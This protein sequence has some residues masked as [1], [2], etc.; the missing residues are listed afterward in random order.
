MGI[1][2][3]IATKTMTEEK[4]KMAKTDYF[5]FYVGRPLSYILTVPFLRFGIRPNVVSFISFFPPVIGFILVGFG[6][7]LILKLIGWV[8]FF[9]WNL[10]DGVDGNIARYTKCSSKM[11]SVW[12]AASGYWAAIMLFMAM[13]VGSYYGDFS[14]MHSNR[15]ISV[16]LG[17]FS[18]LFCLFPRLIMHKKLS[19]LKDEESVKQVKDR[20]SFGP[21]RIIALNLTSFAGFMQVVMLITIFFKIM[22][23]FTIFYFFLNLIIMLASLRSI[24][25]FK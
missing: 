9:L 20:G 15:I 16:V 13:G 10:L 5:A 7:N 6:N 2:R 14:A 11:G 1:I 17:S 24:L 12:D 23:I 18:S 19:T 3:D 21:I 4:R 22:D 8:M 25:T